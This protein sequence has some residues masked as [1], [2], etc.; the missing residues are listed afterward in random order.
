MLKTTPYFTNKVLIKRPYIRMEWCENIIRNPEKRETEENGRI[1]H[2]GFI[3][4]LNKYIPVVTLA[5]GETIHNA[6]PD[7]RYKRIQQ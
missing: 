6:F 2:C 1:R 5:D 3:E 7:R 4:E